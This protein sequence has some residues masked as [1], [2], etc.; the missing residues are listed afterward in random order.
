MNPKYSDYTFTELL[1]KNSEDK[2]KEIKNE[3]INRLN[4]CKF[5]LKTINSYIELENLINKK[6]NYKITKRYYDNYYWLGH[7][8]K[9]FNEY[10]D[11]FMFKSLR[12]Y[13]N[14]HELNTQ[15]LLT[16]LDESTYLLMTHKNKF[17]N[18]VLNE[19]KEFS[20][21]NPKIQNVRKEI[22]YRFMLAYE[23]AHNG[24]EMP[25]NYIKYCE[26]FINNE[27]R[28]I[29]L[30]KWIFP[31]GLEKQIERKWHP[32]TNEYFLYFN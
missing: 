16:L 15:D 10:N 31:L 4:F 12:N 30:C 5:D 18:E 32:Y 13:P 23:K 20:E 9:I 29:N 11:L 24:E 8:K 14:N 22:T 28:I 27:L 21:W 2:N 17:N 25:D 1:L 7:T 19:L 6:K 3:I 26:R